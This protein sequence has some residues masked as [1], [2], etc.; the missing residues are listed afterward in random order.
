VDHSSKKSRSTKR[1][2]ARSPVRDNPSSTLVSSSTPS[3]QRPDNQPS[4]PREDA[5]KTMSRPSTRPRPKMRA[6]PATDKP[7]PECEA[8][9]NPAPECAT[10]T[11]SPDSSPVQPKRGGKSRKVKEE[12]ISAYEGEDRCVSSHL[13]IYSIANT[14]TAVKTTIR[15]AR[16][17]ATV[18]GASNPLIIIISLPLPLRRSY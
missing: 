6:A 10:P 7:A 13:S 2:V 18:G 15:H 11:L 1:P 12:L 5:Q 16:I 4:E 9:N 8:E 14:S 3:R 17:Y